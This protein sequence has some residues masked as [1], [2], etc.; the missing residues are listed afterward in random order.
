MTA[1]RR[2]A[3]LRRLT[4]CKFNHPQSCGASS[5]NVKPGGCSIGFRVSVGGD[6]VSCFARCFAF[7]RACRAVLIDVGVFNFLRPLFYFSMI[8][9]ICMYQW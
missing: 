4:V 9:L 7:A 5:C 6:G 3:L 8:F 2:R 1:A